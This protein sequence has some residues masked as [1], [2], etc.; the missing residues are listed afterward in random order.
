MKTLFIP[1]QSNVKIDSS[2]IKALKLPKSI[3]L[4][5]SI[6]YKAQAQEIKKILSSAY[7]ITQFTQILGCSKLKP[8]E[9][10]KAIL[11]IS[12][13]Q[14]HATALAYESKLPVYLYNNHKLEKVSEKEIQIHEQKQK[15]AYVKYLNAKRI[16]VLI[17]TKPGQ[18]KL[19]QALKFKKKSK[20]ETYLFI[21]NNIDV[22][23]FENF[24][25]DS[26][27]NTACSRMDMNNAAVIN[28]A[29]L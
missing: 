3:A 27:V 25:L 7:N 18:Q 8:A 9:N 11:L 2:K 5:Y 16:G 14:F 12:D 4:A 10:T 24:Q 23:E 19:S 28:I 13:G 26:Y 17:S 29:K 6:Q 15:A 21:T 1:A 20:K 22:S